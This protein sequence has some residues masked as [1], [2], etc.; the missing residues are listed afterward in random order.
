M[1]THELIGLLDGRAERFLRLFPYDFMVYEYGPG[2]VDQLRSRIGVME[3]H[4]RDAIVPVSKQ[5]ART[6]A[7]DATYAT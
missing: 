2:I 5:T 3:R 7:H 6:R 1:V 4:R